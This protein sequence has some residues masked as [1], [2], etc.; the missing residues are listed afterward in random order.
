MT[1]EFWFYTDFEA[2]TECDFGI[3]QEGM[4]EELSLFDV[5]FGDV[6]ICSGQSNMGFTMGGIFNADAELDRL[7]DEFPNFRLMRVKLMTSDTPQDD[8]MEEDFGIWATTADRNYARR[9]SAVCLLTASYMADI[10]GKDKP[11]G[12]IH[13]AWGGT[14]IEPWFY[15][16]QECDIADNVDENN[17]QQSNKYLYNAM[18]HPLVRSGIKGAM[19][20]Q[21][22]S[23]AGWNR[24]KYQCA[25][26]QL[27]SDWKMEFQHY[28]TLADP[29]HMP[30]GFVQLS[31][32]FQNTNPGTPVIRWHQTADYGYVPNE[33]LRVS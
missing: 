21:G 2:G 30:F 17:P 29:D 8:L 10:L 25:I 12:L 33:I 26:K 4:D 31:T 27:I 3:F 1:Y 9:F 16:Q 32:I 23:N 28:G 15:N 13:T 5:Q 20:Y 24:D 14:R 7:A 6:W 19:W 11:F 18:I 22:E